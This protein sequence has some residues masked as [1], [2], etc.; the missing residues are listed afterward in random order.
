MGRTRNG[1]FREKVGIQN[2]L[3]ELEG[4]LLQWFGH[5]KRLGRIGIP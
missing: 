5:V 4:K 3:I 2:L 1:I